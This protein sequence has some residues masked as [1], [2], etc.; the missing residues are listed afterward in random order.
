ML[1]GYGFDGRYSLLV[2][3]EFGGGA[4]LRPGTEASQFVINYFPAV[5]LVLRTHFLTFQYDVEVAP[6]ALFQADNTDPSW[7]RA[8]AQVL[9]DKRR[10]P[11]LACPG[12]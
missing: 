12:A 9:S 4:M 3:G 7:A 5:P 10:H 8:S 6:V 2:G 11:T 1:V